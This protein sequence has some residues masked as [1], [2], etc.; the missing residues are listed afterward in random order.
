[1]GREVDVLVFGGVALCGL[2]GGPEGGGSMPLCKWY[3]F[4]RLRGVLNRNAVI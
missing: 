2:F 3:P 1:M 4:T